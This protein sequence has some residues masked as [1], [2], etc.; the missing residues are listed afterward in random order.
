[1]ATKYLLY[2]RKSSESEEQQVMSIEAQLVELKEFAIKENLS[3]VESFVESRSAKTPGRIEFGKMIQRIQESEEPMGILSWH[4]DRLAR[5]SMDGGQIIY[6][7]DTKK[8]CSL[9]FPST[10]FEPTPQ[11]LFMLNSAFGQSKYF[12]DNLSEVVKRGNRQKL[13]RGEWLGRAPLGYVNNPKTR[14]IELDPLKA[15][16][17]R[18]LFEDYGSGKYSMNVAREQLFAYGIESKTGKPLSLGTIG[19]MLENPLYYGIIR[20]NGEF[21]EAKFE[22]LVTK[23]VFDAVQ[24]RLAIRSAPR[25]SKIRHGFDFTGLL[26]CGEC[27]CSISGQFSKGNGGTYIYYRCTKKKGK[28]SQGYLRDD[29]VKSQFI[30]QLKKIAFPEGWAPEMH[31]QIDLWEKE[32][33]EKL[34]ICAQ[35]IDNK[36]KEADE[37]VSKLVDCLLEGTVEKDIYLK[38]KE[39]L[40]N[41]KQ[42]LK[43]EKVDLSTRG[44]PWLQPLRDWVNTSDSAGK[45]TITSKETEIRAI[46]EKIGSNRAV[47]GKKIGFDFTP[48][49]AEGNANGGL[50]AEVEKK[51]REKQKGKPA[52]FASFPIWYTKSESNRHELTSLVFETCGD[53]RF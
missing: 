2:A 18:R 15:K 32:E 17:I 24:K 22:P 6:M 21:Y 47:A 12:S 8:I 16:I 46:I 30:A 9:R 49:Y 29:L 7:V 19:H 52:D 10:W 51:G 14:N 36:I 11:G 4:P 23:E 45:L 31:A 26:K 43:A 13:R 34:V 44:L 20:H 28:C 33:Q 48:A 37:Q 50:L 25:H 42:T 38:K 5:N 41:L 40:I 53:R 1:M 27:G 3:I 39:K 35:N